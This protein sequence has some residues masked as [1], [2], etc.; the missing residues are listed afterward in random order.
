[1]FLNP[2]IPSTVWD[3]RTRAACP[4]S[5]SWGSLFG[6]RAAGRALHPVLGC[7]PDHGNLLVL[8]L[9]R[10]DLASTPPCT[11]PSA[12]W[13]SLTSPY[14][15]LSFEDA[16]EHALDAKLSHMQGAAFRCIALY[17]SAALTAFFLPWWPMTGTWLC[18]TLS[19]TLPSWGMGFV[20][21]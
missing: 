12:T 6:H 3:L 5:S 9:I 17:S 21:S 16:R 10:L 1:M 7:V 13:A 8:L 20:S 14:L 15:S 18:V 19:T 11:L 2:L 4:D